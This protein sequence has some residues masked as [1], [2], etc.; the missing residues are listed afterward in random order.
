M[1]IHSFCLE[2]TMQ[3]YICQNVGLF[4]I[5]KHVKGVMYTN[6][7]IAWMLWDTKYLLHDNNNDPQE[8]NNVLPEAKNLLQDMMH[9]ND[10]TR[11]F[12]TST[13]C[14]WQWSNL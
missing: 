14:Q 5:K 3:D 9:T 8:T 12:C 1:V 13:L 10:S 6:L 7:R 11:L 4:G 2:D